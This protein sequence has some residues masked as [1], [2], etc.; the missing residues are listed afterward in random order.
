MERVVLG[1]WSG[2]LPA[3]L[4]FFSACFPPPQYPPPLLDGVRM[5]VV[6]LLS[7]A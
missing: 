3:F 5:R 7:H 6:D 2:A 4:D 1:R